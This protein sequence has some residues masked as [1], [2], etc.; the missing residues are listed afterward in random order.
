MTNTLQ[1][2]ALDAGAVLSGSIMPASKDKHTITVR[3]DPE[4]HKAWTDAATVEGVPLSV[5]IQ[6]CCDAGSD[7]EQLA[8]WVKAA[9]DDDRTLAVW[10]QR[11]CNTAAGYKPVPKPAPAPAPAPPRKRRARRS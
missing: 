2:F 7:P 11:A 9:N 4:Q 3:L 8:A 6:R 10:I 1:E 5:W